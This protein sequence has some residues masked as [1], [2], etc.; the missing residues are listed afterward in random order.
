MKSQD[1][2]LLLNIMIVNTILV[3]FNHIEM[4]EHCVRVKHKDDSYAYIEYTERPKRNMKSQDMI[5]LLNSMIVNV[6][7]VYLNILEY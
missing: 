7:L 5:L 4:L 1:M 3:Y 2:I 6:F